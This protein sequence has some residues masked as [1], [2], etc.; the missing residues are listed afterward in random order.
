MD[1]GAE[2]L[3]IVES[4]LDAYKEHEA[5]LWPVIGNFAL[6]SAGFLAGVGG[7]ATAQRWLRR[8]PA[9]AAA[10]RRRVGRRDVA[11]RS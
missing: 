9:A 8:P 2:A 6:L 3:G 4:H 5:S 7:I 1:V 11:R 10:G